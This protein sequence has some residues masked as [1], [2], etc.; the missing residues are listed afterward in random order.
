MDIRKKIYGDDY[1][2]SFEEL[3]NC[4]DICSSI[5][6]CRFVKK[7]YH[8]IYLYTGESISVFSLAIKNGFNPTI[9]YL[10]D[11]PFLKENEEIMTLLY[12]RNSECL[13][14]LEGIDKA[15][16]LINSIKCGYVPT[17]DEFHFLINNHF[18]D[19]D[20]HSS[21]ERFLF[22]YHFMGKMV[23]VNPRNVLHY[24]GDST[25]VYDLALDL[26]Y[27]P[28]VDELREKSSDIFANSKLMKRLISIDPQFF[29]LYPTSN[30]DIFSF[31]LEKGFQFTKEVFLR[32]LEGNLCYDN[33][34]ME[35]AIRRDY[36]NILYYQGISYKVFSLAFTLGFMLKEEDL[37]EALENRLRILKMDYVFFQSIPSNP[38]LVLYYSGG[39]EDVYKLAIDHGF[40]PTTED[41]IKHENLQ[42]SK[43][44][45]EDF[46]HNDEQFINNPFLKWFFS[47][48]YDYSM[49]YQMFNK[50]KYFISLED[51]FKIYSF[52][53]ISRLCRYF[54]LEKAS[55]ILPSKY[56]EVIKNHHLIIL[57]LFIKI[58]GNITIC[59]KEYILLLRTVLM[60][61]NRYYELIIDVLK[62]WPIGEMNKK[63]LIHFLESD[64][65]VSSDITSLEDLQRYYQTKIK[66]VKDSFTG[67]NN[68]DSE[69]D[70]K[71]I[72]YQ[73][74]C[75]I[76]YHDF[77]QLSFSSRDL[78]VLRDKINDDN[79]KEELSCYILL[80]NYL[81][82][83]DGMSISE[84]TNSLL[85]IIENITKSD[86]IAIIYS[87]IGN[88]VKRIKE[89]IAQEL[90]ESLTNFDTLEYGVYEDLGY[91]KLKDMFKASNETIYDEDISGRSVDYIE[92]CGLD[93]VSLVHVMNA[94]G[95]GGTIKDFKNPRIIGKTY[96]CL[97]GISNEN[98]MYASSGEPV[99]DKQVNN[100]LLL[101]DSFE[102]DQFFMESNTD[103]FTE[104]E[105]NSLVV[106]F[107]SVSKFLPIKNLIASSPSDEMSE[108][109]LF[110]ESDNGKHLYPKA[111]LMRGEKPTNEEI[112]AAAYLGIPLVYVNIEA[113]TRKYR[114]NKND[115]VAFHPKKEEYYLLKD[116]LDEL[117]QDKETIKQYKIG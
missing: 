12:H 114:K 41:F 91:K 82:Q 45:F 56:L 64:E 94:F 87:I 95:T 47:L 90:K 54:I 11:H 27:I 61:F 48:N 38:R 52:S 110:R 85:M 58:V 59:N 55:T 1:I 104:G 107:E 92:L 81:E 2:P 71:N 14:K 76:R 20:I 62:K 63:L 115:R 68:R 96:I 101:F 40:H 19:W 51:I 23:K 39:S 97:S 6:M 105:K 10:N 35:E 72:I 84:L 37:I 106:E 99:S 22:D 111:V 65:I 50:I 109:T 5:I 60:K 116:K 102:Q 77:Y 117:F 32:N 113:Y 9:E 13:S 79:I 46:L 15:F 112:D 73:L 33:T 100:V 66:K 29:E 86:S 36:R 42:E 49:D 43:I 17:D 21:I 26:G 7:D 4:P 69:D 30:S 108:I 88:F 98:V 57:D 83:F 31:A 70:I 74:L 89:I 67:V 103:L 8:Y 34:I 24:K 93:Y 3:R 18:D 78:I 44:L 16:M 25:F 53:E 80:L 28:T 75:G